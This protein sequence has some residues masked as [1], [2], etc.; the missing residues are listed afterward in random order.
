MK[1]RLRL[2]RRQIALA[3]AVLIPAL[4]AVLL[5]R[6][7]KA[8]LART[9]P[10][11]PVL[12]VVT[13]ARAAYGTFPATV[14]LLGTIEAKVAAEIAPRVTGQIL[15]VRVREGDRVRRGDLLA[16][17]DDRPERDRVAGLRAALDAARTAFATQEAVTGRDRR[18]FEA[19]ALS[20]EALDRS[21]AALEAARARVTGLEKDLHAAET[22]LAYTRL[23]AP[24]DGVVTARLADPGDLALPGRPVVAMEAPDRGYRV[25]V[26]VPQDL[27][28]VL[29]PGTRAEIL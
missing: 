27:F 6:H 12:P 9:P 13:T 10:P 5:V 14:R 3:L 26:R 2:N 29:A 1:T 16:R 22:D 20:R 8:Q 4:G 18:L 24:F 17:L 23:E 28:P 11:A 21:V 19:K 7:R 25:R 15:E